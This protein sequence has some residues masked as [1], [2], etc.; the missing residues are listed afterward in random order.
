MGYSGGYDGNSNGGGAENKGSFEVLGKLQLDGSASCQQQSRILAY[1]NREED[2]SFKESSVKDITDKGRV[3]AAAML[4]KVL[5]M[6]L[7]AT[8]AAQSSAKTAHIE[9]GI[10][11]RKAATAFGAGAS[12]SSSSTNA[13]VED[14]PMRQEVRE[15]MS[16][17]KKIRLAGGASVDNAVELII[18][19]LSK[20]PMSASCLKITKIAT[21][22]NQPVW[23]NHQVAKIK[24]SSADLVQRWRSLYRGETGASAA[25]PAPVGPQRLRTTSMF[26]EGSCHTLVQK[27]SLYVALMEAVAEQLQREPQAA[28]ELVIGGISSTE[29]VKKVADERKRL[30]IVKL[31]ESMPRR[32][33]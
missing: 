32:K 5:E 4:Q 25:A 18:H 9:D 30:D 7:G 11:K 29:F 20:Q 10:L 14:A 23:R 8:A 27:V 6:L 17:L 22:I 1:A 33:F 28:R 24:E 13:L 16:Q 2:L 3:K 31:K 19:R 15:A 26:L 21:E 12:S